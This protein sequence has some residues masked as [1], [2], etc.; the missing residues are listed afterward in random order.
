MENQSNRRKGDSRQKAINITGSIIVGLSI[1][2]I[3]GTIKMIFDLKSTVNKADI[4][5]KAI[6]KNSR[7]LHG[8]ISDNHEKLEKISE[9]AIKADTLSK[10]NRVDILKSR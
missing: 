8:R 2:A 3:G 9:M 1:L 4:N 6:E 10:I 5:T 7:I